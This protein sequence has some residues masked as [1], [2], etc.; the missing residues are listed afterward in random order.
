MKILLKNGLIITQDQKRR[1]LRGSVLIHDDKIQQIG[2]EINESVEISIDCSKC[3][4][5]PGLINTHTHI[6]MNLMRSIADDVDLDS[7]LNITFNIDAKRK[8]DD[9]YWGSMLGCL[10]AIKSGTTSFVDLYYSEDII[11]KAV[12]KMGIR[13]FLSWVTLDKEFTTQKGIPLNNAENFI[14]RFQN[15]NRIYPMIGVQ[16]VYV[17]S[18]DTWLKAKDIALKYNTKIHYHLS[19]TKIEVQNHIKKTG[20]TPIQWL[21]K[22]NVLGPESLVAHA[23]WLKKDE[24]KILKKNKIIISHNPISNMK[25]ASGRCPI[26][27]LIKSKIFISLGT[28]GC[29]S[30]NNLDMFEEMKIVGLLHKL[31]TKKSEIISSQEILDMATINGAKAIGK[32]SELGSIEVG[33]KAD[34]IVIDANRPEAIPLHLGN[35]ISN[36]VYSIKG[37]AVKHV[38]IDGNLIMEN[39]KMLLVDENKIKVNAQAAAKRLLHF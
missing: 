11:A 5:L 22:I 28:D 38:I 39:Y 29:A 18:E 4:I 17:A 34:I 13:G 14:K 7:F 31:F 1:I 10:E 24:I 27:K 37:N 6:S 32:E 3:L 15:E 26:E 36:I 9:I 16:G 33:K 12:K 20:L 25:L 19:E 8:K 30:N 35:A 23:V 2:K 21:D